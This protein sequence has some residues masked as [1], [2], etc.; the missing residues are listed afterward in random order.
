ME[1]TYHCPGC[2]EPIETGPILAQL[3]RMPRFWV[4]CTLCGWRSEWNLEGN[5]TLEESGRQA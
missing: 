4:R 5:L 3:R 2:D 1:H